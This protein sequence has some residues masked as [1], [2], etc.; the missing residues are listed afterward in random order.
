MDWQMNLD[1]LKHPQRKFGIHHAKL[2][3]NPFKRMLWL[4]TTSMSED[5]WIAMAPRQF[6]L[7]DTGMLED[8]DHTH[9]GLTCLSSRHRKILLMFLAYVLSIIPVEDVYVTTE[10]PDLEDDESFKGS[11][12]VL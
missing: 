2:G 6:A 1:V 8:L 7:D 4:G 5:V 9:G 12:N 10:Y 11:S 3:F